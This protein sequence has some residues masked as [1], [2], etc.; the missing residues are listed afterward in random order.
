MNRALS[1][2]NILSWAFMIMFMIIGVLNAVFVHPVPGIFYLSI[3]LIYCPPLGTVAMKRLGL[4]FP[5]LFK[6]I[7]A[8]LIMWVTLAVG[9][10]AEMSGL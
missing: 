8:F 5:Y 9:D 1:I 6:I 4:Q 10:L 2:K 3:S 7:L